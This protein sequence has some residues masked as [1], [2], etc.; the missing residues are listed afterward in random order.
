MVKLSLASVSFQER[1]NSIDM[2][3]SRID[4]QRTQGGAI[5][6]LPIAPV[7]IVM[8]EEKQE[9]IELSIPRG[10]YSTLKAFLSD[11]C[12]LGYTVRSINGQGNFATQVNVELQFAG[13]LSVGSSASGAIGGSE[14]KLIL[15]A[16]DLVDK[17]Q[18]VTADAQL[19]AA[20]ASADGKYQTDQQGWKTMNI[21]NVHGP[22]VF[23]P[24]VW[25]GTEMLV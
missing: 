20:A 15:L 11:D 21:T 10:E 25:S 16:Q 19:E 13:I 2:C 8:K 9:I 1:T 23:S 5:I 18:V 3:L 6:Q 24:S 7:Q 14:T 22:R 4:L 17:L 12:E